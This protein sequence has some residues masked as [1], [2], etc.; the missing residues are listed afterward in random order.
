MT[1]RVI[2]LCLVASLAILMACQAGGTNSAADSASNAN[3]NANAAAKT[4]EAA[5]ANSSAAA[6]EIRTLLQQHD[7]ALGEK[8]IDNLLATFS[9]EPT[10]VVLGTGSE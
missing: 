8:N 1:Q 9:T 6:D 4:A 2:I 5:P 7:K 3:T 10:T